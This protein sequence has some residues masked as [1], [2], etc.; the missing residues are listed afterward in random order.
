MTPIPDHL[1]TGALPVL[2][3]PAR[4]QDRGV[5]APYSTTLIEVVDRFGTSRERRAILA[6]YMALR[7]ELARVKVYGFQWLSGSFVE[8]DAAYVPGDIDVVSWAVA[9]PGTDPIVATTAWQ[10]A[11]QAPA[12]KATYRTDHYLEALG[13]SAEA[14]IASTVYWYELWSSRKPRGTA[15]RGRKGFLR[16]ELAEDLGAARTRLAE[17]GRDDK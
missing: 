16:V 7:E 6:G 2:R 17:L 8:D 12:S 10:D 3:D 11:I 5:N 1:P 9:G 14:V 13:G 15:S 4:P